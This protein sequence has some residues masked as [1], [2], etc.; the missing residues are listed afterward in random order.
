MAAEN[1]NASSKVTI[2]VAIITLV[3]GATTALISNW[4]K[5]FGSKTKQAAVKQAAENEGKKEPAFTGRKKY[6]GN[7]GKWPTEYVLKWNDDGSIEGSYTYYERNT[8]DKY[9]LRGKRINE[10]SIELNEYING[11]ETAS[12]MLVKQGNC[13]TGKIRNK[14]NV[15]DGRMFDMK[16][17]E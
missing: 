1:N 8:T 11:I 5:I 17:C 2:I 13:Y 3:G 16:I 7:V 6:T 14:G 9:E 10:T 4:D 15:N 12:A